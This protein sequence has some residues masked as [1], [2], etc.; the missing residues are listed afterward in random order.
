MHKI[1]KSRK[2]EDIEELHSDIGKIDSSIIKA[3]QDLYR[4]KDEFLT[5]RD[6]KLIDRVSK[7]LRWCSNRTLLLLGRIKAYELGTAMFRGKELLVFRNK[8]PREHILGKYD[9]IPL[10]KSN[11]RGKRF[12]NFYDNP[13]LGALAYVGY[14]RKSN[15]EIVISVLIPKIHKNKIKY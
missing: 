2:R 12:K 6:K 1:V 15:K 13:G 8:K 11:Y 3:N 7:N 14:E 10:D 4:M 9:Y 5:I